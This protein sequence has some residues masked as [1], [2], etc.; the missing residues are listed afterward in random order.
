MKNYQKKQPKKENIKKQK[1]LKKL[2]N[3]AKFKIRKKRK[4]E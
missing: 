1:T 2:R 3:R 4:E